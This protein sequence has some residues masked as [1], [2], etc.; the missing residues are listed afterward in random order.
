VGRKTIAE[1]TIT[2]DKNVRNFFFK[3]TKLQRAKIRVQYDNDFATG[4]EDR[5]AVVQKLIIAK[6]FE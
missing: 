6:R 2:P 3:V 4:T 1:Y 5:N